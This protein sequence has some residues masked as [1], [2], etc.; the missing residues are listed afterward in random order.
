MAFSFKNIQTFI[1]HCIEP[2]VIAQKRHTDTEFE[3]L[4][5]DV[6]ALFDREKAIMDTKLSDMQ[7]Q[8]DTLDTI[9]VGL[10]CIWPIASEILNAHKWLECKGQ[11]FDQFKY[12]DLY[13]LFPNGR[14]PNYQGVFLRGHGSQSHRQN[15]GSTIGETLT[16]H[17]SGNLGVIQGDAIREIEGT[18]TGFANSSGGLHGGTSD[19]A[20]YAG[21]RAQGAALWH[22]AASYNIAF[23]AGRVVP[24]ATEN[25]PAN[26]AVRYLIRALP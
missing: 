24:T 2:H 26:I 8:V 17:T 9:P 12:P 15:N 13:R 5:K 10:V 16:N 3:K 19:G 25:R 1:R 11:F 23:K 14:V 6:Q 4:K 22:G 7:Q 21:T 20:I 18:T